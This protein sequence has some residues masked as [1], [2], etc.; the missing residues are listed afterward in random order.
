MKKRRS[1]RANKQL[2][3]NALS[4]RGSVYSMIGESEKAEKDIRNAI[5]SSKMLCDIN[6][7]AELHIQLAQ[8]FES[9]SDFSTMKAN[10]LIAQKYYRK[11]NHSI[12]HARAMNFIGMFFGMY[13]DYKKELSYLIKSHDILEKALKDKKVIKSKRIELLVMLG[14]IKNNM[15]YILRIPGKRDDSIKYY[16]EALQIRRKIGDKT[17]E[18][19]SLNNIGMFYGRGGDLVKCL[20]YFKK[21]M[22]IYEIIG[23]KKGLAGTLMN[24]GHTY[25]LLKNDEE[26]MPNFT[27]ALNIQRQIKDRYG[28][29]HTLM[30]IGYYYRDKGDTEKAMQFY[31]ESL[32]IMTEIG[33]ITSIAKLCLGIGHIYGVNGNYDF[34]FQYYIRAL[35][36]YNESEDFNEQKLVLN[37]LVQFC[38][39]HPDI[40]DSKFYTETLNDLNKNP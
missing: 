9:I 22:V 10:A 1:M 12:G 3:I 24:M 37:T 16:E 31:N 30:N 15:G 21:A 33:S 36:Q 18:A 38:G 35:Q 28:E 32:K 40:C 11:T 14:S 13:G 23:E 20:D 39:K 6:R 17:G 26:V 8:V 4:S 27:A 29:G 7:V 34:E 5:A 25:K 19:Q 2:L